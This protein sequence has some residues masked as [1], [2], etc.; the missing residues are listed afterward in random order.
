VIFPTKQS[1]SRGGGCFGRQ[2][3]ALATKDGAN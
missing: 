2:S 3:I 1:P